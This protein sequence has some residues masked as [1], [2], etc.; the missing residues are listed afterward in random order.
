MKTLQRVRLCLLLSIL[1]VTCFLDAGAL[2]YAPET[3]AAEH[4]RR[5]TAA[6]H[7]PPAAI[8]HLN[9]RY[10]DPHAGRFISRDPLGD[11]LNWYAYAR[12]NPLAFID[13]TGLASRAPN[14]TEMAHLTAA[15]VFT[16]GQSSADW[17]MSSLAGIEIKDEV[18]GQNPG[19]RGLY[20][21]NRTIQIRV[22]DLAGSYFNPASDMRRLG[23]FIH[24]LE[25]LRQDL[26]GFKNRHNNL[27]DPNNKY[28]HTVEQLINVTL[29]REPMARA[30]QDWFNVMYTEHLGLWPDRAAN[31]RYAT[32][33]AFEWYGPVGAS[34]SKQL[35]YIAGYYYH[36]L[37][38]IIRGPRNTNKPSIW[39]AIK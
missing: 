15:A 23:T 5:L 24:E 13:P 10:Y 34:T 26:A 36:N 11:G 38:N 25:H 32:G 29:D 35:V 37:L 2:L 28:S 17:L 1:T 12:N 30:V 31:W 19:N 27:P 39:G 9:V 6:E 3:G 8:Y 7:E 4:P 22:D 21:S 14:E 18:I 20:L 16:F 33:G